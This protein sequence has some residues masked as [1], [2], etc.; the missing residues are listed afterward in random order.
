MHAGVQAG[1]SLPQEFHQKL[2]EVS[3][4]QVLW[5]SVA[6]FLAWEAPHA[7]QWWEV[8]D[9]V[10]VALSAAE[11]A[12][13]RRNRTSMHGADGSMHGRNVSSGG[14]AAG[15][16]GGYE[17]QHAWLVV[18][19]ALLAVEG[20]CSVATGVPFEDRYVCLCGGRGSFNIHE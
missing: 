11:S 9:I 10:L 8:R 5:L 20:A 2:L 19:W 1:C 7:L 18:A 13:A 14:C 3:E 6:A 4:T 17:E 15:G 12:L 16:R